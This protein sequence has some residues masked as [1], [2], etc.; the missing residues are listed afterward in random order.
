MINL[1]SWAGMLLVFAYTCNLR[2]HLLYRATE[3]PINTYQVK[4]AANPL[5]SYNYCK[6][7]II[8]AM[9]LYKPDQSVNV[10]IYN[11][12]TFNACRI[13]WTEK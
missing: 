6:S 2:P 12:V 5:Y 4:A 9:F 3:E 11:I 10:Y 8:L 7:S 13:F 1:W